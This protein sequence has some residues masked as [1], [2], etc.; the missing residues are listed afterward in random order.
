MTTKR[1]K[2]EKVKRLRKTTFLL[3]M[4]EAIANG[5]TCDEI[6]RILREG[7]PRVKAEAKTVQ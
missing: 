3:C 1:P 2:F 6:P 7:L 4:V 5:W